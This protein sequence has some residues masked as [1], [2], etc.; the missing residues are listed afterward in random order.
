M[1]TPTLLTDIL[2]RD[3]NSFGL[4]RLC[5]ATLVV[6]SHAFSVGVANG[7]EPLTALTGYSLGAHAVHAFFALSGCLVMASWQ[8]RQDVKAFALARL[9][10]IF[11]ALIVV[12]ALLGLAVGPLVTR[13]DPHAYYTSR[14]LADF[15]IRSVV[16]LTG[17]GTLPGVFESAP[18]DR[19]VDVPLWT[20]K[21]EILCYAA[22]VGLALV[23][24]FATR[25]RAL[26]VLGLLCL[27][28]IMRMWNHGE[29]ES[30]TLP[31]HLARLGFAFMTGVMAW[32]LRDRLILSFGALATVIGLCVLLAATPLFLPLMIVSVAYGA[33]CLSAIRVPL[34]TAMAGRHDISYG[35]YIM[36]YPAQKIV[37]QVLPSATGLANA[38]LALAVVAPLAC[39]SWRFIERPAIERLNRRTE[40]G[41]GTAKPPVAS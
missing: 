9:T 2:S 24:T 5:A 40:K 30:H 23:G 32:H 31:D 3:R 41:P 26:T 20:L 18:D 17:S 10:R 7:I 38:L 27:V 15:F 14:E 28:A 25:R 36:G 37:H 39:L 29:A 12:T 22:L 16:L 19:F 35:I 8:R 1:G 6:V 11:P 34:L 21:Y 33:F 4:I 13:L